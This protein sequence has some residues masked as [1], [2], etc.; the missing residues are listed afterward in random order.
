M[1]FCAFGFSA[2]LIL[3][4]AFLAGCG[5]SS[6]SGSSTTSN[7]SV[8][9]SAPGSSNGS[10]ALSQ[11]QSVTI[12]A[13]IANDASNAGVKW[14]L[15]G[16][17]SLSNVST[18]SATYTA[19]ASVSSSTTATVTATSLANSAK[20][21]SLQI[22]ISAAS[23]P[24]T[25]TLSPSAAQ[26]I[27]VDQTLPITAAVTNDPN[28]AGVQWAVTIALGLGPG[29]GGS[30]TDVTAT[31]AVYN[32]YPNFQTNDNFSQFPLVGDVTATSVTDPTKSGVL[33][34]TIN[35]LSAVILGG[36]PAATF[37]QPYSFALPTT[38]LCGKPPFTWYAALPPGLTLSGNVISGVPTYP[39]NNFGLINFIVVDSETPVQNFAQQQGEI[40]ENLP[41]VLTILS[42]PLPQGS[43]GASYSQ[44]LV[45]TAGTPPYTWSISGGSLPA[46]LAIN[47]TTGA[48]TGTPTTPGT[49]NFTVK[50]VDS[51]TP[52]ANTATSNLSIIVQPQLALATSSL[53]SGSVGTSYTENL[54]ATGGVPPYGFTLQSGSSLP[55]GLSLAS[56]IAGVPSAVG[57]TN[58]TVVVN[59][60]AGATASGNLSMQITAA[61]CPKNS[62]LQGNYAFLLSGPSLGGSFYDYVGSFVADGAGTITSGYMDS[63][64]AFASG[65]QPASVTGTY[66]LSA[67]NLGTVTLSGFSGVPITNTFE[68]AFQ[69]DGNGS[70]IV[71][72]N[73]QESGVV[74]DVSGVFLKQDTSAF[75]TTKIDGDYAFELLGGEAGDSLTAQAGVF[76]ADGAGNLSNGEL[77]LNFGSEVT[78]GATFSA[79]GLVV[80]TTGRGTVALNVAGLGTMNV[81]FYVVNT[82]QLLA[83]ETGTY[84][85]NGALLAGQILQQGGSSYSNSSLN[86]VS[87]VGLQSR[88]T[89]F[90]GDDGP[91]AQVGLITWDGA[92]NFTLSA[93]NNDLG[94]MSAPSYSGTYTVAANGR[95]T[96]TS[97]GQ[98]NGAVLYLTGPNQAFVMGTDLEVTSG[99][100][101]NQSGSPFS[102][103][104]FSGIYFGGIWQANSQS[105]TLEADTLTSDGSGNVSGTTDTESISI[106]PYGPASTQVSGTYSVSS[107][108]RGTITQSG[109]TTG[110][111][112]VVSPTQILMIPNAD[113][114]PKVITL[115]H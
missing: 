77:D 87:V 66:C 27:C 39:N 101:L 34:V 65:T 85:Q 47:P 94:S 55:A 16:P 37:T 102:K 109:A 13:A 64:A 67:N 98:L 25:V 28:N 19:P 41:T 24:I 107:D 29:Q 50:I 26:T 113:P 44:M 75:D 68:V 32:T 81:V 95:V 78:S 12:S 48:I 100:L 11:G 2:V 5:S 35:P 15:T 88:D 6:S 63:G 115:S 99:S 89:T 71:Y 61:N 21:S 40:L 52:T 74:P 76:T 53:P 108:G 62:N 23:G 46:G 8:S 106:R 104:S 92:G 51:A 38:G 43:V 57:T 58:F 18:T 73:P 10:I 3:V 33:A 93:D 110:I 72:E 4:A 30:L 45:A 1:K 112:Y 79:S 56:V 84:I 70:A 49:Y 105:I 114:N 42:G 80:A 17:G 31:S 97:T 59:D 9:L 82:T 22:T 60:S 103:S 20:A 96:L 86:G 7:V 111:F 69:A 54:Q 90:V 14:S 83:L 36:L 91:V